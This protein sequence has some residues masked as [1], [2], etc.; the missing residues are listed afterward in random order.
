MAATE[1]K[2][3]VP[4]IVSA[5]QGMPLWLRTVLLL[6]LLMVVVGVGMAWVTYRQ[7]G[8]GIA[9]G[10]ASL[11][12][13]GGDRVKALEQERNEWRRE[14]AM[15]TQAAE[16]DKEAL[17]AIRDQIKSIQ[18]ERLKMEEELT[19][20]RGIVSTS[21]KKQVLRVQ[22]F[23]LD[24]GLEER[25]YVYRF[26]VSQ[27]INSGMVVKGRIELTIQGLQDGQAKALRLEHLS[28]EKISSH[29]MRFRYFQK[30]EGKLNLP[31][32]FQPATITIDVKP[33]SAKLAPVSESYDWPP[34]S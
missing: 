2:Y 28:E 24:S 34:I 8:N 1:K 19:F 15:V 23:K 13:G 12:S 33:S 26:S 10:F 6:L 18:D 31:D 21:S 22:N 3:R 30:V 27:V 17:L 14:L 5:D 32:G 20:L 7:G 11:Q 9:Q 25:Q 16:V 29:K 4:K